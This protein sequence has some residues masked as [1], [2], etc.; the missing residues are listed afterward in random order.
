MVVAPGRARRPGA[1][2]VIEPAAAED[3]PDHCPFCEGHEAQTPPETFALAGARRAPDVP[4]WQVRIVPNLYPAFAHHEVVVHTPR[5]VRSIADLTEEELGAVAAAWRAR[6]AALRAGGAPYVQALVNEG[7]AA[8]ASLAHTHSQLVGLPA[9]PPAASLESDG[10]C[11]LCDVLASERDDP[12]RHVLE[13]DGVVVHAAYA[14]RLPYELLVAPVEHEAD[15]FTS[16]ALTTA[17]TLA[18]EAVRRLVAVEGRVPLNAWLHDGNHWHLEIVPRLSVLAG[19]ELG[20][21]I[22]VNTLA[23]EEAAERLRNAGVG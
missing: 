7:R 1:W 13:R 17:L 19:L 4:G 8:G 21:G 18:A 2:H 23:P 11:R 10:R 20:A 12:A 9:E 3:H 15:A 14:G 5:H 6:A 16:A 22:Y